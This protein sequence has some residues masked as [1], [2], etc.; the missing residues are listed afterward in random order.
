M[1]F[2]LGLPDESATQH[3]GAWLAK[4]LSASSVPN[5]LVVYLQGDL[6]AGKTTLV[7]ALLHSSGH[8]GPVKSPTYALLESYQV[9]TL[10]F[11]HF[12]FYRFESEEEFLEAGLDEYFGGEGICLIEW[13]D[14]AGKFLP[15][16]D[17][18][19]WLIHQ[20]DARIAR[21]VANSPKGEAIL[22]QWQG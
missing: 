18:V 19:V 6:G 11:H 16:A 22:V 17:V 2:E 21:V 13:P 3:L 1:N 20:G 5:G 8:T 4:A 10:V 7:R 12:D 9:N 14:K 15:K